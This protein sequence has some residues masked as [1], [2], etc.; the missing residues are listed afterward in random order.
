M[1]ARIDP[2]HVTP[3]VP[4]VG[5]ISSMQQAREHGIPLQELLSEAPGRAGR[6]AASMPSSAFLPIK[7]RMGSAA[8]V[9]RTS[10]VTKLFLIRLDG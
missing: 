4:S 7:Q 5:R 6:A 1:N 10:R 9:Q 3:A 2:T 8:V